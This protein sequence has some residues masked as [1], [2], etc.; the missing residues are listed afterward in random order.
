[1]VMRP[2]CPFFV[3][4]IQREQAREQY[5]VLAELFRAKVGD[6][7][8]VACRRRNSRIQEQSGAALVSRPGNTLLTASSFSLGFDSHSSLAAT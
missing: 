1:M 7:K 8:T 4:S 5:P 3:R 2:P 6:D